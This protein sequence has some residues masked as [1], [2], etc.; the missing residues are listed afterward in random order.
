M[1]TP[2]SRNGDSHDPAAYLAMAFAALNGEATA[3][4]ARNE[5][6]DSLIITLLGAVIDTEDCESAQAVRMFNEIPGTVLSH[7]GRTIPDAVGK[8]AKRVADAVGRLAAAGELADALGP[9]GDLQIA[10]RSMYV[11]EASSRADIQAAAVRI[12]LVVTAHFDKDTPTLDCLF[13][14]V[15]EENAGPVLDVLRSHREALKKV[16]RLVA[17]TMMCP[18]LQAFVV[19]LSAEDGAR[20]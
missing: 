18:S 9:K 11:F 4:A 6:D 2:A 7:A 1:T 13:G 10:R 3:Q 20:R 12:A 16:S 14:L 17:S 15:T 8:L 5:F 19:S